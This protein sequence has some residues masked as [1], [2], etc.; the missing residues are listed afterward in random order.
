MFFLVLSLLVLVPLLELWLLIQLSQATD[1]GTT[2][3]I[4]ILTGILGAAL[5]RRQGLAVW[6]RI[7]NQLSQGNSPTR[8]LL[9]GLM[10]LFAGAFLLTPGILTDGVGFLL[11]TPPVRKLLRGWLARRLVRPGGV[12]FYSFRS[13][14]FRETGSG[15]DSEIEAEYTVERESPPAGESRLPNSA[16]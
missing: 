5:A 13:T 12:E 11:L 6:H 2:L 9:D 16:E 14:T 10:I 8:E 4:V 15:G 3:A 7:Q 1:W